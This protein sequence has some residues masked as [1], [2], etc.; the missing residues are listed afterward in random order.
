MHTHLA[1]ANRDLQAANGMLTKELAREKAEHDLVGRRTHVPALNHATGMLRRIYSCLF[2]G[3]ALSL[4]MSGCRPKWHTKLRIMQHC[5]SHY[6]VARGDTAYNKLPCH[7]LAH[8][9]ADTSCLQDIADAHKTIQ[10]LQRAL[11]HTRQRLVRRPCTTTRSHARRE[12]SRSAIATFHAPLAGR[13]T[14]PSRRR[15]WR[16][17]RAAASRRRR[18]RWRSCARS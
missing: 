5:C 11:A 7:M 10:S 9:Y 15:A 8:A 17:R 3:K 1:E 4:T 6:S 14:R 16:A 18:A 13:E 12:S 2:C